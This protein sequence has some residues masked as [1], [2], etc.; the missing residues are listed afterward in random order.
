M[1]AT[2]EELRRC[3]IAVELSPSRTR[4]WLRGQGLVLDEPSVTAIDV[5]TGALVAVGT[6]AEQM[7]G[8]TPPH[9]RTCRPISGATVVDVEMAQRMLRQLLGGRLR[10]V[11]RRQ[12]LLR[13]AVSLPHDS[14][15]I[16]ARAAAE[17]LSGIG[18]HR[19]TPVNT[20]IA[21]ALGCGLPA[22]GPNATMVAVCDATTTQIAVLSLGS[23]VSAATVPIGG[24][25]IDHAI[26]SHLRQRHALML[27]SQA[28][29]PLHMALTTA[30][31]G[32]E[33]ATTRVMGRDA[34]SG[35]A[36][37]VEVDTAGI[38]QAIGTPM[39]PVLDA[40]GE[41]LRDC[42]PDLVADLAER[43]LVLTGN[44]ARLSGLDA[45]LR[46]ATG[47]PVAVAEDPGLCAI[48]GLG[49]L[50]DGRVRALGIAA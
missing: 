49:A 18:A 22:Q 23:I 32:T 1:S 24:D 47:M 2:L 36:L 16:A 26:V 15:P 48:R 13:A 34:R 40:L 27:P 19:V 29:Q 44:T 38:K 46:S 11:R 12:P 39:L 14:S 9:I 37:T 8:R 28:V 45:M 31:T 25:A 21:A 20:V 17:T 42:P 35:L 4:V 30:S 33:Q 5:R 10:Q 3:T 6:R 41:V 7:T 50:V 43:G